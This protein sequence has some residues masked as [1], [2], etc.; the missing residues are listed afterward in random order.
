MFFGSSLSNRHGGTKGVVVESDSSISIDKVDTPITVGIIAID[1]DRQVPCFIVHY[2]AEHPSFTELFEKFRGIK[3]EILNADRGGYYFSVSS[4]RKILKLRRSEFEE[5]VSAGES[6]ISKLAE[7]I[8]NEGTPEF[9]STYFASKEVGSQF[10]EILRENSGEW[11]LVTIAA[12][13]TLVFV[14]REGC[15]VGRFPLP[16][17]FFKVIVT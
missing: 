12:E 2:D 14:N 10:L 5:S 8:E 4:D 9:Q 16:R 1:E 3:L 6:G 7:K 13:A 17:E 15:I 11:V